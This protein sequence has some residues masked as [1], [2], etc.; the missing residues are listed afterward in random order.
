MD[1][2]RK[3]YEDNPMAPEAAEASEQVLTQAQQGALPGVHLLQVSM[4]KGASASLIDQSAMA[5][6]VD[7][8]QKEV[9][10]NHGSSYRITGVQRGT[11]PDSYFITMEM[12][13]EAQR[14]RG[15]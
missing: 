8:G 7:S 13:A 9:L 1:R 3:A 4:P 5:G 15:H 2:I 12:L 14:R 10:A 6:R 11:G